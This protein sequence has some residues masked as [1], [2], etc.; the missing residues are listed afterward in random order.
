MQNKK[1]DLTLFLLYQNKHISIRAP[2]DCCG[3]RLVEHQPQV[4]I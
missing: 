1:R 3:D 2:L 4:T